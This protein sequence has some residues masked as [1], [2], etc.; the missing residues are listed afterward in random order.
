MDCNNRKD[1]SGGTAV[2]QFCFTTIRGSHLIEREGETRMKFWY[3]TILQCSWLASVYITSIVYYSN[4]YT[5]PACLGV[6]V[7]IEF[8]G[9]QGFSA[10]RDRR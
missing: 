9:T 2:K 4:A 5:E 6:N 1:Y 3:R 10:R 8:L 7:P